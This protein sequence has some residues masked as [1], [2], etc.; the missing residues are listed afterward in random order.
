[1]LLLLYITTMNL[2]TYDALSGYAQEIG[3]FRLIAAC[4]WILSQYKVLPKLC[5]CSVT[6]GDGV[7]PPI[8]GSFG[9]TCQNCDS[10]GD[11]SM[12]HFPSHFQSC[13]TS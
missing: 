3:E 9:E 10:V 7:S 1:M 6:V 8:C 12:F 13:L 5:T 2:R 4:W 11:D